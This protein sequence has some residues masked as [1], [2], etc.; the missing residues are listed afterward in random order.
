MMNVAPSILYGVA[1]ARNNQW[2]PS[3]PEEPA[4]A[5]SHNRCEQ[6]AV[7]DSSCDPC[8]A[9]IVAADDY[10]GGTH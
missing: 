4:E 5:C 8:V 6:G 9:Q 1:G 7:L 3:V 10:C 2:Q